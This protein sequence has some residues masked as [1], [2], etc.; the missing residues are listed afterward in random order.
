M[1]NT[2]GLVADD[3]K[4]TSSGRKTAYEQKFGSGGDAMKAGKVLF[5]NT[6]S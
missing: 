1:T 3:L 6:H 2:P 4:K 5:T